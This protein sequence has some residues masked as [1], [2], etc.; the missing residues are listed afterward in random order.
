[1]PADGRPEV[2]APRLTV[3]AIQA[4]AVETPLAPERAQQPRIEHH[5]HVFAGRERTPVTAARDEVGHLVVHAS[6]QQLAH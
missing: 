3:R 6:A 4:V 1:M 2:K 5:A